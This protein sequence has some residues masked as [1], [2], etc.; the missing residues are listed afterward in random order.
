[1]AFD[2][3]SDGADYLAALKKSSSPQATGAATAP[4]PEAAHPADFRAGD[5]P[6]TN[7]P[8]A[9]SADKRKA[10][11]YR[12]KGSARLQENGTAPTWAAFA[13]ISL[14][15]CYVEAA[16]PPRVGTMVG[17]TL[18]LNGFRVEASGEVR[19]AYPNL[20][21]GIH[22]VKISER[23]REQLRAMVG[24]ISKS[25]MMIGTRVV[26]RAP[27]IPQSDSVPGVTNP[28]A[29]LQAILNFFESRHVMGR[30]E[31]LSLLRKR[32]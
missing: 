28:V 5:G 22:F 8:G 21:M 3:T 17:L 16:T 18:E 2:E 30:E 7:K 26:T 1:M 4:A 9:R 20:G 11:R 29:T 31:F 24:S 15:G 27:L 14:H 6:S 23:N 10:P 12:C 13:D 25:S 19:V 32:Q